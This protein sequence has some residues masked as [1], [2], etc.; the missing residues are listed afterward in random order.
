MTTA[1]AR[2]PLTSP[3]PTRTAPRAA[4]L[5]LVPARG[6]TPRRAP[7]VAVVVGLLAAGLLVLL[8]LNTVLAQDAFRLH[9]LQ[10]QAKE[11]ADQEQAL[12]TAVED[13][14]AP[15]AIAQRAAALQ[16]VPGGP[17]AF[18]HLP[19]G[20]VSGQGTPAQAPDL[21]GEKAVPPAPAASTPVTE[22]DAETTDAETTD[23]DTTDAPTA[24]D[25][26]DTPDDGTAGSTR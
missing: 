5:R 9:A 25:T 7:F 26:T 18:L 13:L 20:T 23:A 22:P 21:V 14:E 19:D 10:V 12:S 6:A 2:V 16:M 4:S 1:A 17:P 15:A 11:L 3:D 24:G 8:V